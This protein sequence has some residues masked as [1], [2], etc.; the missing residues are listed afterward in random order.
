MNLEFAIDHIFEPMFLSGAVDQDAWEVTYRAM[1]WAK[2]E[3]QNYYNNRFRGKEIIRMTSD[4]N[5]ELSPFSFIAE[6]P[7]LIHAD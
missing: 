1:A 6:K 2:P 7:G 3:M 4:E 5:G